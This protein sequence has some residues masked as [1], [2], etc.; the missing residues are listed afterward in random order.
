MCIAGQLVAIHRFSA[1][2]TQACPW[3]PMGTEQS[4]SAALPGEVPC[5][6]CR[7]KSSP[8]GNLEQEPGSDALN[9]FFPLDST[10]S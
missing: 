9:L 7:A 6:G 10:G 5:A 8:G 4:V 3:I 1:L 2:V